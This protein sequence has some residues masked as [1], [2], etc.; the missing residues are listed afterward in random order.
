M[1]TDGKSGL[2]GKPVPG[3][4][5]GL[6]RTQ[7]SS[8]NVYLNKIEQTVEEPRAEVQGTERRRDWEEQGEARSF[9]TG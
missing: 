7:R 6:T 8:S 5:G 1:R 2:G 3:L 4:Q 9:L